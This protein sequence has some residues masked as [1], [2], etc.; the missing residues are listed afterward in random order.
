MAN[1]WNHHRKHPAL[2]SIP[3]I[4]INRSGVA[5]QFRQAVK[6]GKNIQPGIIAT[7]TAE[8]GAQLSVSATACN[9]GG[10]RFWFVCNGCNG[11]RLVLRY[12]KN[13]NSYYCNKCLNAVHTSTQISKSDRVNKATWKRLHK[14]K[15]DD[16]VSG[17]EF[18]DSWHK[19]K[20]MH[21]R[22]WARITEKHN[23]TLCSDP[24]FQKFMGMVIEER[25]AFKASKC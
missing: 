6:A 8:G 13:N 14:Y 1:Y 5:D 10:L 25:Q 12:L 21:R 9:Y 15:L 24:M 11:N 7:C 3:A 2:E 20:G 23:E 4:H 16:M 19:P 22:T 17:L 18:L